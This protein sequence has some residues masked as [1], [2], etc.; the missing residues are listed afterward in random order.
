MNRRMVSNTRDRTRK[1]PHNRTDRSTPEVRSGPFLYALAAGVSVPHLPPDV[2]QPEGVVFFRRQAVTSYRRLFT[3]KIM[4]L[5]IRYLLLTNRPSNFHGAVPSHCGF[6]CSVNTGRQG[7]RSPFYCVPDSGS[8]PPLPSSTGIWAGETRGQAEG[9]LPL[10]SGHYQLS[11]F[12]YRE[13]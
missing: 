5:V 9:S 10:Q 2:L 8:F 4:L 7:C 13:S 11:L 12:S 3:V 6:C 1:H